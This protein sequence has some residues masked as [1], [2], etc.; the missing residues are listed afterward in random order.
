ME[1]PIYILGSEPLHEWE[2][3]NDN[4]SR[5]TLTGN[6]TA[7]AF[8]E[9]A[10]NFDYTKYEYISFKDITVQDIV[11]KDGYRCSYTDYL[12]QLVCGDGI[13]LFV[14]IKLFLNS[15]DTQSFVV[16]DKCVFSEDFKTLVHIPETKEIIVPDYVEHIGQ[17]ACCG[18][19][20]VSTV[21]LSLGLKSIGRWAFVAAGID[22]L[23]MPD[24]LQL[25]GE[26][27]FLM[28]DLETVKL[29]TNLQE[30]P[31]GCF[32]LCSLENI[33]IPQS[34]RRIGNKAL[35][36]LLWTDEIDI[37]EGVEH[38]GYDAFEAMHHVSLLSTLTYIAPDFYYEECIDD[39]NNPPY[40]EVHRDNEVFFSKDGSLYFRDTGEI[41]IDSKYNGPNK[42]CIRY[43][44]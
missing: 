32:D 40:I 44:V 31:D 7:N 27:A 42:C 3:R 8:T 1:A 4:P 35:R 18:Y 13:R 20:E 24:S 2:Q 9:C 29:S 17:G 19:D 28:S 33:E 36:G 21:K 38:I 16:S 43:Q 25:L 23:D 41:A 37:P 15:N 34:V 26:N 10:S 30:I 11:G 39:P 6:V 5:I 12:S 14:L 22:K